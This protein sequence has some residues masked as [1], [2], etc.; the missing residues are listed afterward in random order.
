MKKQFLL[1]VISLLAIGN[2]M[3]QAPNYQQEINEQVWLPFIESYG[4]NNSEAFMALHSKDLVRVIVDN[5]TIQLFD[6]YKYSIERGNSNRKNLN[7]KPSIEFRFVQRIANDQAAYEVGYY[8]VISNEPTGV[9]SF[10][11]KFTV[12]LRKEN[13]KWKIT[14]DSDSSEGITETVFNSGQKM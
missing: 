2:L 11:G 13:G 6:S 10:Y 1:L 12:V 4:S 14:L 5:K 9:R 7:I 8:K 3:A